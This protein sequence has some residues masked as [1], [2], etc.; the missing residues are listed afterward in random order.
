METVLTRALDPAIAAEADALPASLAVGDV[1]AVQEARRAHAATQAKRSRLEAELETA[2]ARLER[3][4]TYA[5]DADALAEAGALAKTEARSRRKTAKAAADLAR[6]IERDLKDART[7]E[8]QAAAAVQEAEQAAL[9]D[10]TA[11]LATHIQSETRAIVG[12]LRQAEMHYEQLHALGRRIEH[13]M[14]QPSPLPV[15]F[16]PELHRSYDK[17][18]IT[19]RLPEHLRRLYGADDVMLEL[20]GL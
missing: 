14:S 3:T 6:R 10:L 17:A 12:H 19:A 20:F 16:I 1:P 13:E 2:R 11:L 9:H 5:D 4:E 7:A 15:V 18:P 8:T